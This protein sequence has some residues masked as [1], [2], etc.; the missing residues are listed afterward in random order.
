MKRFALVVVVVVVA[1]AC[2][3]SEPA[4]TM[5][6]STAKP[7][8][9]SPVDAVRAIYADYATAPKTFARM[10]HL[11]R[12]YVEDNQ[13]KDA[14]CARGEASCSG[15][16]FACLDK[17][18]SARGQL[19]DVKADGELPGVSATVKVKLKFGD[20]QGAAD[21]DAVWED[22]AWKIDQVRCAPKAG[23]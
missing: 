16:R 3:K 6:T 7:A 1:A 8:L 15:D 4:V 12:F 21:V 13:R 10:P 2:P 5:A 19:V 22:G 14:A 23:G 11:S 18:P 9:P 20:Q 17:I